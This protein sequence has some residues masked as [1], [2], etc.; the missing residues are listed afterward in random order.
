LE[1]NAALKVGEYLSLTSHPPIAKLVKKKGKN[2]YQQSWINCNTGISLKSTAP[3]GI[4]AF[5][6]Y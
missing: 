3:P 4:I 6:G 1:Q 2:L 5:A